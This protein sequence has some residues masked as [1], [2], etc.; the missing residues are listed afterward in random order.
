MS[1]LKAAT[2]VVDYVVKSI[3]D[4][5]D[6]VSVDVDPSA[7]PVRIN[8]T[9]DKGDMGRVIGK[10]GRVANSIRAL[11]RS[12]ASSEGVDIDLEFVE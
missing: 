4:N 2:D 3:V 9:V 12:A 11:G 6:A 5:P 10:R 7:S 1:E 8:V